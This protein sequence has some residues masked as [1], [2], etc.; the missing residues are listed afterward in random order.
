M[1][2]ENTIP[3]PPVNDVPT[4]KIMIEG[5]EMN[6]SYRVVI[7]SVNK[8]L[9]R[10]SGAEMILL[11]GN[12]SEEDF[13][14]SNTE[15][16][17]PGKKIEIQ[18]GYQ[19]NDSTIFKGV[20]VK[21]GIK[22]LHNGSVLTVSLKHE[23]YKS[24]LERKNK[25]FSDVKDS[26]IIQDI[27]GN[28]SFDKEVEDTD[29]THESLIQFNCSDWDFINMRAEAMGQ[30]VYAGDEKLII[31]KPDFAADPKLLL[32]YGTT[33]KEFEAEMDGRSSFSNY[34]AFTWDLASQGMTNVEQSADIGEL[35]QGNLPVMDMASNLEQENFTILVNG[36]RSEQEITEYTHSQILRNNLSRIKGR[37]RSNG[38]SDI[39]PG[40]IIQLEGVG[41]RFN[42]KSLVS[43]V[44]HSIRNGLW[45]THIQFG[46]DNKK[47]A[48]K[49]DNIVEK[50][51]SGLLPSV[52]GLQV[53]K[54][55]QLE[56]D[57][58]NEHRIKIR[59]PMITDGENTFWARISSLDAGNNRGTYFRPE[60]DDEV[61]V[62]FIDDNPNC[63]VVLGMMNSSA[64]PAPVEAADANNIK[65]I[66]T[67]SA[68][69]MEFD[70]LNKSIILETPGGNKFKINDNE[71]KIFI[72]DQ[73]G[74]KVTLDTSGVVLHDMFG[75]EVKMS[76]SGIKLSCMGK[77]EIQGSQVQITAA[78]IKMDAAMTEASGILKSA[79]L[80]TNAV[81]AST[82]TPG[83][84][85]VW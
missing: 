28:Y 64:L 75:N 41:D 10:I 12:V 31:K 39:N 11:D 24:S 49:F 81:I 36:P 8:E 58:L 32:S 67:R 40:D 18:A 46:L 85:N 71:Q 52:H 72:E 30:L 59:L 5:T 48:E 7:I 25:V 37:V 14:V 2:D 84:G 16:L 15:D 6:T 63:A 50:Q 79:A 66:Y 51:A 83:A 61:I 1:P 62:G 54:V 68:I 73:S 34:N 70:D 55:I 77:I 4:F 23:A 53:G 13:E 21:H 45:E 80:Q 9:G 27:I 20:I 35:S 19:G 76:S 82:Y 29:L 47:Y 43:G 17:V 65:G 26:D 22:I 56:G 33:I 42:G 3:T 78:Q 57:P 69:K 60:I 74:N 38:V 44:S